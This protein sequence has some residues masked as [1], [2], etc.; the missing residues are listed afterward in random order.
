MLPAEFKK[1]ASDSKRLKANTLYEINFHIRPV[2][3]PGY[4]SLLRASFGHHNFPSL[5]FL[6]IC[7]AEREKCGPAHYLCITLQHFWFRINL[8][9]FGSGFMVQLDAF[10]F[11]ISITQVRKQM[12]NSHAI[13]IFSSTL[14]FKCAPNNITLMLLIVSIGISLQLSLCMLMFVQCTW[15]KL[16]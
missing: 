10:L 7:R 16:G 8:C 6:L 11:F 5:Y 15:E 1:V 12:T 14:H 2:N 13:F 3:S 4:S 9:P